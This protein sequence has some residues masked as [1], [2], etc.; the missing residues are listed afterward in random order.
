M[1]KPRCMCA[2]VHCIYAYTYICMLY[3]SICL[4]VCLH[5]C[6]SLPSLQC[7]SRKGGSCQ[8]SES[9][10]CT[11]DDEV[12]AGLRASESIRAFC[13]GHGELS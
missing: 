9:S 10:E 1:C 6:L 5:I 3:L 13:T 12:N 4:S 11:V 8:E 7:K 2:Y